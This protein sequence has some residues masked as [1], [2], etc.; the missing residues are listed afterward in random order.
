MALINSKQIQYP[1]SGSFS[2][3]FSGDGSGLTNLTV[4][5][6]RIASG[7]VTASVSPIGN[8]FLIKS[9]S[10]ELMS[11][12]STVTTI[13]NDVF[14][15]KNNNNQ[16]T[17]KVSESIVYFVTQSVPLTDPTVAGGIYFTSSSFYVGLEN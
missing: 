9:A 11:I 6:E 5:G 16:S 14:L 3:S 10:T 13:T 15:V 4:S 12:T 17:F 7:S 8:L 1:L 2:G